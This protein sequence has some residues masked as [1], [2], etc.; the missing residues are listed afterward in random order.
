MTFMSQLIS[1]KILLLYLNS[2]IALEKASALDLTRIATEFRFCIK[3]RPWNKS[4]YIMWTKTLV[5]ARKR[6]KKMF[7]VR[8]YMKKKYWIS[9]I[10]LFQMKYWFLMMLIYFKEKFLLPTHL[11]K[12]NS[13]TAFW[14]N[15]ITNYDLN[16]IYF[17][18]EKRYFSSS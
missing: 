8:K 1:L 2:K 6:G 16:K 15:V 14:E 13:S 17:A 4:V 11:F 18:C 3:E 12:Q 9:F 5:I 7:P 10:C